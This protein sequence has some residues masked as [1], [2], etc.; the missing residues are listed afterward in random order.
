LLLSDTKGKKIDITCFLYK[1][2][3]FCHSLH[4]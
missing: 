1:G 3:F 2:N 4:K